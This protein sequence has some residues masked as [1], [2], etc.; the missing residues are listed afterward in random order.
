MPKEACQ[1]GPAAHVVQHSL[2]VQAKA[3]SDGHDAL[4]PEGALAVDE[5][6]LQVSQQG[7]NRLLA[8]GGELRATMVS[9][10]P[11]RGI[12][13]CQLRPLRLRPS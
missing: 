1:A 9:A 8:Q 11:G 12:E 10:I 6:H 13:C 5:R 2:W 7:G 3:L 4:R